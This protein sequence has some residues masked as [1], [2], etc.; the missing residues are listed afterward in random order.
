MPPYSYR[1][2]VFH[3][4]ILLLDVTSLIYL[5]KCYFYYSI[6]SYLIKINWLKLKIDKDKQVLI[7][8]IMK[9][10]KWLKF[11]NK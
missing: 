7:C 6:I 10:F 8:F 9:T 1:N 2:K 11:I 3:C 4:N 5:Y